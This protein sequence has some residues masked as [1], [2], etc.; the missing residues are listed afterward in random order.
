MEATAAAEVTADGRSMASDAGHLRRL[1]DCLQQKDFSRILVSRFR[2]T[3]RNSRGL[4]CGSGQRRDPDL[5]PVSDG[6]HQVLWFAELG[7]ATIGGAGSRRRT[8]RQHEEVCGQR[9]MKTAIDQIKEMA[10]KGYWG[11]NYMA[12]IY[13]DRRQDGLRR[14]RHDACQPGLAAAGCRPE[15]GAD[16]GRHR[17][18]RDG[19]RRQ[20]MH[21]VN[22]VGPTRFVYSGSKNIDA[23]KQYSRS[24]PA[25]NLQYM[26]DKRTEVQNLP[27]SGITPKYAARQGILRHVFEMG[28]VLQT[29]VKYVNRS[30][31]R[32]AG[33]RQRDSGNR[34]RYAMLATSTRTAQIRQRLHKTQPG[35]ETNPRKRRGSRRTV[36]FLFS[37]HNNPSNLRIHHE[38]RL[39]LVRDARTKLAPVLSAGKGHIGCMIGG[40]PF[41]STLSLNDDT[42]WS[43]YPRV[44]IK[45]DFAQ[46]LQQA[47]ELLWRTSAKKRKR[48]SRRT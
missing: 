41:C 36:C 11:D 6:W 26:V 22:P 45:P 2:K 8:Q 17:I 23:A 9:F 33:N 24:G 4:R 48:S 7:A 35:K 5:R 37:K 40:D 34:R 19:H 44:Y 12:D 20:Q 38:S 42:L 39:T 27:F 15:R 10:D 29:S 1:G 47:R 25:E 32:S 13:A 14:L 3:G 21:H 16:G 46:H 18:L 43:G 31:W 28:T 30:G